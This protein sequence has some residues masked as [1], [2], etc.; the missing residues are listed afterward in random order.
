ML[1]QLRQ[2]CSANNNISHF[3]ALLWFNRTF[4]YSPASSKTY[5]VLDPGSWSCLMVLGP[6][7]PVCPL[8]SEIHSWGLPIV[9]LLIQYTVIKETYLSLTIIWGGGLR[10]PGKTALVLRGS[11]QILICLRLLNT[12]EVTHSEIQ[13]Q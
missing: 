2:V 4:A 12:N 7:F 5:T 1:K 3:K 10:G 13:V 11:R 8:F 6:C 9:S